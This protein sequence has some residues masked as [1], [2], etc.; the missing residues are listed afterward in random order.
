MLDDTLGAALAT[1]LEADE[2]AV[3]IESKTNFIR[4]GELG[5]IVG[6]ALVEHRGRSIAFL[7]GSLMNSSGDVL[8]TATATARILV[9]REA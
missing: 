3:T 1:T 6:E 5:K 2:F 4:P 9:N 7:R 8:A